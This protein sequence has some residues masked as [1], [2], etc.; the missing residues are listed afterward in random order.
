MNELFVENVQKNH[1]TLLT[2]DQISINLNYLDEM[3]H[4]KH[5]KRV[6]LD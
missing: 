5:L 1:T 4:T 3:F 6:P 2:I